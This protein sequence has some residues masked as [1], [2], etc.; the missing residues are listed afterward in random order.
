MASSV[1]SCASLAA[2]TGASASVAGSTEPTGTRAG[3]SVNARVAREETTPARAAQRQHRRTVS[4]VFTGVGGGASTLSSGGGSGVLE[5]GGRRLAPRS[6]QVVLEPLQA[7]QRVVEARGRLA[8][9]VSLPRIEDE[10]HRSLA[11]QLQ[12]PV[13]LARLA[14]VHA[15]IVLAVQD[16]ERR[17][18]LARP[19]DRAPLELSHPVVPRPSQRVD[20]GL[21]LGDVRRPELRDRVGDPDHHHAGG[22]ALAEARRAPAGREAAVGTAGDADLGAIDEPHR[23]QVIH[24]V[25]QVVELLP[26]RVALA[27]LAERDA[28]SGAA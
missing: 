8:V 23:D 26:R 2:W 5:L 14:R 24:G 17:P 12:V 7:A 3:A 20:R 1:Q 22:E 6:L 16:E 27:E 18:A 19:V 21:L 10:A 11:A 9:A 25:D 15:R 28:A 13:E 4:W